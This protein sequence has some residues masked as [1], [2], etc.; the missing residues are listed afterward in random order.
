[1]GGVPS[2]DRVSHASMAW[3]GRFLPSADPDYT[4]SHRSHENG[5]FSLNF[6]MDKDISKFYM[7]L[8]LAAVWAGEGG[9]CPRGFHVTPELWTAPFSFLKKFLIPFYFLLFIYFWPPL[10]ACGILALRPGIEPEP[11]AVEAQNLN[12]WTAREVPRMAP[13]S[14]TLV[15]TQVSTP[16]TTVKGDPWNTHTMEHYAGGKYDSD[17]SIIQKDVHNKLSC[18][19]VSYQTAGARLCI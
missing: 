7:L 1:M 3:V 15:L 19:K 16:G 8:I 12:H 10:A 9:S 5:I 2:H 6:G 13:F 18:E 4:V 14:L 11:P 17:H